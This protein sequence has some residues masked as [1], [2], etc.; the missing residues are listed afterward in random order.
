MLPFASTTF[1]KSR[2]C[3]MM[4]VIFCSGGMTRR[5]PP[6]FCCCQRS[7][8][9]NLSVCA[10]NQQSVRTPALPCIKDYRSLQMSLVSLVLTAASLL[11][12]FSEQTVCLIIPLLVRLFL[13]AFLFSPFQTRD[14]LHFS[15]DEDIVIVRSLDFASE[16][17]DDCPW[18]R[19]APETP[20]GVRS[21][22]NGSNNKDMVCD[23]CYKCM[24][25]CCLHPTSIF[26]IFLIKPLNGK[27]Y[28]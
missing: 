5:Q 11:N 2:C 15:E 21:Q 8:G 24:F 13:Y 10:L 3:E 20:K 16:Y 12:G 23:R 18:L 1:S 28:V 17:I 19:V 22:P 4:R 27:P 6:T 9:A 25:C 26:R 14:A 7:R